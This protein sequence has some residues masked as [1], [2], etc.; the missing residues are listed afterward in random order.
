MELGFLLEYIREYMISQD[1]GYP[2]KDLNKNT[3][4][5]YK[6]KKEKL[7]ILFHKDAH[8]LATAHPRTDVIRASRIAIVSRIIQ[9]FHILIWAPHPLW[10]VASRRF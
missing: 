7:K 9:A 1:T 6:I 5:A 2:H 10:S 3:K 4:R 8:T